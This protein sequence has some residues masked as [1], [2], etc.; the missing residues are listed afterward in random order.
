MYI[1]FQ[2]DQVIN[3]IYGDSVSLVEKWISDY[4]ITEVESLH[5]CPL[6]KD[7]KMVSYQI[8][9]NSSR[10]EWKL[11]KQYKKIHPG[12]VYNTS[13][14]IKEQLSSVRYME[15]NS[16]ATPSTETPLWNNLNE[17]INLR[18]IKQLD[19][20]SLFQVFTD[21]QDKIKS[22]QTWTSSEYTGVVSEVVR[23][24]KKELYSNIAKK[25]KRF[26]KKNGNAFPNLQPRNGSCILEALSK[27]NN[28]P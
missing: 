8:E 12:Y 2:E 26:G 23:N 5:M 11:M 16:T 18:V 20:D 7:T 28:E 14:K 17:E 4:L 1:I 24:F 13:E 9:Q 6:S 15:Y 22:K 19:K 21:I 25:L 3:V 10:N 27:I